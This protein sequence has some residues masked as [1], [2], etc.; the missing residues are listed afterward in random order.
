MELLSF[1]SGFGVPAVEGRYLC[2]DLSWK[3]L[4]LELFVCAE[5]AL[6]AL[7]TV[8]DSMKEDVP[9]ALLKN[10]AE[11]KYCSVRLS[12]FGDGVYTFVPTSVLLGCILLRLHKFDVPK[13]MRLVSQVT[14]SLNRAMEQ[15]PK[16][17]KEK[18]LAVE[19]ENAVSSSRFAEL[20]ITHEEFEVCQQSKYEDCYRYRMIV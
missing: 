9:V 13:K 3:D 7:A 17:G 14:A 20:G 15:Y 2:D 4:R 5:L 10:Y 12:G 18:Q 8:V 1:P 19:K 6:E 11:D 16:V